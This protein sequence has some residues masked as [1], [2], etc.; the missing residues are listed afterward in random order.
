MLDQRSRFTDAD[1]EYLDAEPAAPEH[2]R[3]ARSHWAAEV[4]AQQIRR[5]ARR[6]AVFRVACLIMAAVAALTA[7]HQSK[8]RES[9]HGTKTPTE[10]VNLVES[11]DFDMLQ[12]PDR[13][14]LDRERLRLE[15]LLGRV[16]NATAR[17]DQELAHRQAL[18]RR[19]GL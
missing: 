14:A 18:Q 13:T 15:N 9:M 10:I 1:F 12:R 2:W 16:H 19:I 8:E 11:G 7:L 6:V 5:E 17:I 3:T 4:A